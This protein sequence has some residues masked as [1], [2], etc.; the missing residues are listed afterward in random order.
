M[1]ENGN[2]I[3]GFQYSSN[4]PYFLD[5]DTGNLTRER[6]LLYHI[7]FIDKEMAMAFKLRWM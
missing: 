4:K 1:E 3:V 7:V 6:N 5:Y 2:N